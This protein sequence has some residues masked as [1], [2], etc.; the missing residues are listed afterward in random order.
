MPAFRGRWHQI[1]DSADACGFR[2]HELGSVDRFFA[3]FRGRTPTV[4]VFVAPGEGRRV[5]GNMEDPDTVTEALQYALDA[6]AARKAAT[7]SPLS[8]VR[9]VA[10][11]E[12]R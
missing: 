1:A 9:D 6:F 2:G 4:G 3:A 11:A 8:G 12:R 7:L 5:H 10:F